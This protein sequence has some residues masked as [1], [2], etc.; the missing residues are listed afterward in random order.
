MLPSQPVQVPVSHFA[1]LQSGGRTRDHNH[2]VRSGGVQPTPRY[3]GGKGFRRA[4]PP[5]APPRRRQWRAAGRRRR[6]IRPITVG[7]YHPWS[8]RRLI[9][10]E[11]I[12]QGLIP[13]RWHVR[14]DAMRGPKMR[15][16][17]VG[18]H[19]GQIA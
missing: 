16:A 6:S 17:D 13:G 19:P 9:S 5:S 10:A 14:A 18:P 3:I 12:E 4:G 8:Q 7:S 15:N 1:H 11:H 2:P